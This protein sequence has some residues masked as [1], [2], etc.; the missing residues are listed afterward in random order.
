MMSDASPSTIACLYSSIARASGVATK[1]GANIGEIGAH[2][3]RGENRL[4]VAIA[5]D[6]SRGP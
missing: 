5:P 6:R 1:A 2:H 4:P 3:L